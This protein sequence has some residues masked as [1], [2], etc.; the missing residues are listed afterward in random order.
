VLAEKLKQLRALLR[1]YGSCLV[2]YSGGV[3]SVF[4]WRG[5]PTSLV[6]ERWQS[7]PTHPACRGGIEEA[8]AVARNLIS[9]ARGAHY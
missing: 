5:P 3:D 7:L 9:G 8:L 1:S 2:A 6:S 4:L